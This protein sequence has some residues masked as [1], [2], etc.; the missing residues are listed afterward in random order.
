MFWFL[1]R[2]SWSQ[3]Q[4][5]TTWNNR[6]ACSGGKCAWNLIMLRRTKKDISD[7]LWCSSWRGNPSL[8]TRVSSISSVITR[9]P[10]ASLSP[11]WHVTPNCLQSIKHG[12][13]LFRFPDPL[14]SWGI[15]MVIMTTTMFYETRWALLG[16]KGFQGMLDKSKICWLLVC[17]LHTEGMLASKQ[18]RDHGQGTELILGG[19]CC[20]YQTGSRL[21]G[22]VGPFFVCC[23][24]GC[25]NHMRQKIEKRDRLWVVN[26]LTVICIVTWIS[27]LR[28]IV[29]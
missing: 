13:R 29:Y 22:R 1:W 3:V 2:S 7:V 28:N 5:H 11:Q 23:Q 10:L 18:K 8:M 4:N 6:L 9:F 25:E 27:V 16:Q 21:E 19:I 15:E 17:P 26:C 20:K 14:V 24:L 12:G